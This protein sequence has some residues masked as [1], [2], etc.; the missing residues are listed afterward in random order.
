MSHSYDITLKREGKFWLVYVDGVAGLTQARHYGEAELMARE[1]ISLVQGEQFDS[2]TI[3][4]ITIEGVTQ[5]V[6][7]AAE[8]RRRAR[9][10]E[11]SASKTTREVAQTLRR[12][13]VPLADIG[14][15][16]GVSHQRAHQLATATA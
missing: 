14:A 13:S 9:E 12:E 11:E 10:L 4:N 5:Q 15:I 6:E 8:D 16:L 2:V 3:G 7:R 1:Y